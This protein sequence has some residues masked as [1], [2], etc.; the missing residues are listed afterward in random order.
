[1]QAIQGLFQIENAADI[2][3]AYDGQRYPKIPYTAEVHEKLVYELQ[4]PEYAQV[5]F[6][7]YERHISHTLAGFNREAFDKSLVEVALVFGSQLHPPH[8]PLERTLLRNGF[9]YERWTHEHP[10]AMQAFIDDA[11]L[12]AAPRTAC[13]RIRR[14]CILHTTASGG[15]TAVAR[16]IKAFLERFEVDCHLLDVEE[17]AQEHDPMKRATGYTYD[18]LYA[19][20]LQKKNDPKIENGF[21]QF[22]N[23]RVAVNRQVAKYIAPRTVQRIKDKLLAIAPDIILSTRNY[24]SEDVH[25]AYSLNIPMRLVYCDYHLF[26]HFMQVGKTDPSLFKFWMP[27][28]TTKAF[29]HLLGKSHSPDD[30]W[31]ETAHK[32]AALTRAPFEEISASFEEIAYPV[33]QEY[34]RITDEAM[35]SSLR[36]KWNVRP[37]EHL[38]VVTM[39][40]NGVGIMQDIFATLEQE[41]T[42]QTRIKYLFICGSNKELYNTLL[43]KANAQMTV[44]GNISHQEMSEVMNI[45]SLLFSKPGGGAAAQCRAMGVPLFTNFAH[46]LWESGNRDELEQ[47]NLFHRFTPKKPMSE[48]IQELVLQKQDTPFAPPPDWKAKIQALLGL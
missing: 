3:V 46:D 28:L 41:S 37:N 10:Q 27:S 8:R 2:L 29:T 9:E 1:M 19:E 45:C 34:V 21:P 20:I 13:E 24:T 31:Q 35:L 18:G 30:S 5:V 16:A 39:G 38:V 17:I 11:C 33:G 47:A 25:L 40:K 12:K 48:Q 6:D 23:E 7:S 22:L 32:I 4:D 43:A 14:V 44:V 42:P 36:E 15:N 26:I